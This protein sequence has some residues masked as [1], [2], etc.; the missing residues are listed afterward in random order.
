MK[1]EKLLN[2][3][4]KID[5]NLIY[6]AVNDAKTKKK[7]IWIK[8][9]AAAAFLAFVI[10]SVTQFIPKSNFM[11]ELPK[12]PMLSISETSSEAMGFEGYMAYEISELVNAN[13]WNENMEISTLPVYQNPLSYDENFI[14]HGADF[15]IMKTYLLEVAN[16]LG[17]DTDNLPISDNTPSAEE[18]A[19]VLEKTN[20]DI[21]DGY[22]NPTAVIAEK[23]GIEIEVDASLTA[24]IT[25]DPAVTLPDGYVFSYDSSYDDIASVA[26]Y[27][28][29]TYKDLLGMDNPQI[30][31]YGG[32]YNIDLQQ[33]Y[34]IE[35]YNAAN[36]LTD[37]I[38]NYNF[39]RTAFYCDENGDLYMAR[40]FQPNLSKKVADYPIISAEEAKE[41]LLNGNY[42]TT[43]PY[44]MP[45]KNYIAK[46]ELV[47]RTSKHEKYYMPYYRFYVEL[48]DMKKD[49]GIKLY[50]VYYVPAVNKAYI[51]DMPIW[52]GSFN[53]QMAQLHGKLFRRAVLLSSSKNISLKLSIRI[54]HYQTYVSV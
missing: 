21:P 14:E 41:L 17:M 30:N 34:K 38:L 22:F 25:F 27:L 4:G 33:S 5:D 26:E 45:G 20:G 23:N 43:V 47:Y 29:E 35:F 28:K 9:S 37:L 1:T 39:N 11:E 18:Q 19:A 42:I 40:I 48:P 32:D 15:T 3:I 52:D 44:E 49:N 7:N 24:K 54:P 8:W 31:I 53:S 36:N 46:R 50:G 6:G 10:F 13:P 2:A 51:T 16:R 12:L